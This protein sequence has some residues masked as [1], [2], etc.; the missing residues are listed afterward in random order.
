MVVM[1]VPSTTET[2]TIFVDERNTN[3]GMKDGLHLCG[4]L[5]LGPRVVIVTSLNLRN[6]LLVNTGCVR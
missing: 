3:S 1:K 6:Y 5:M 4:S 2:I